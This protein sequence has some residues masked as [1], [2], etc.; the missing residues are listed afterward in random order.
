MIFF[1]TNNII[2]FA[3]ENNNLINKIET[4]MK[5]ELNSSINVII[6]SCKILDNGNEILEQSLVEEKKFLLKQ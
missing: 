3:L 2:K 1:P 5:K 6:D 4:K